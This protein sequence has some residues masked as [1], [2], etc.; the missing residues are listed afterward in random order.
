MDRLNNEDVKERL[1]EQ[2]RESTSQA[3]Y[4]KRKEKAELPFSHIKRNLGVQALLLRGRRWG[5]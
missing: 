1:E 5:C 2:Y 3:I 4:R